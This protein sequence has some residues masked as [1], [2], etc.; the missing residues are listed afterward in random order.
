MAMSKLKQS[1]DELNT[2]WAVNIY[3]SD[4]RLLCTLNP[5]HAWAFALGICLGGFIMLSWSSSDRAPIQPPSITSPG[6]AP[7]AID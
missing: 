7:L 4:R 3:T 1:L 6:T 5:S 2:G